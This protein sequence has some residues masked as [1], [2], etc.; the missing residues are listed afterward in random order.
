M[1]DTIEYRVPINIE[2]THVGNETTLDKNIF[3]EEERDLCIDIHVPRDKLSD[4]LDNI[5]YNPDGGEKKMVGYP[6]SI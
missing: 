1:E 3:S 4:C 6:H 5:E 2:I